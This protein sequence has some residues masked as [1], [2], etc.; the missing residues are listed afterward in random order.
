LQ[1]PPISEYKK[2]KD[3]N[4]TYGGLMNEIN[5]NLGEYFDYR[6]V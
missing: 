4:Y 5:H 1:Y 6:F 3:G 2:S